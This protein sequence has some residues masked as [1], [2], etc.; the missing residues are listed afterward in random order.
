MLEACCTR[1]FLYSIFYFVG[2]IKL[3]LFPTYF[4]KYHTCPWNIRIAVCVTTKK[5]KTQFPFI[6]CPPATV[7]SRQ[8]SNKRWDCHLLKNYSH[9]EYMNIF[10]VTRGHDIICKHIHYTVFIGTDDVTFKKDLR[11]LEILKC[12]SWSNRR[13]QLQ[14]QG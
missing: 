8:M 7:I 13:C 4:Q 3:H 1:S 10:H 12:R 11:Q 2:I 5:I 6:M 9:R 14:K